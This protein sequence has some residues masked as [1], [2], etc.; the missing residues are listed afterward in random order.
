MIL[1]MVGRATGFSPEYVLKVAESASH[2]YKA[3]PIDKR[4]GGKR[5]IHQP[6]KELKAIQRCLISRFFERLPVHQAV[7]SY[8][9]RFNIAKHAKRHITN[10]YLLRLDFQDFFPSLKSDD[11]VLL[12]NNELPKLSKEDV[13]LICKIVCREQVLTIGAPSSP[14]LSNALLFDFDSFCAKKA[15]EMNLV[16]TRYSDDIYF[17][18]NFP[19]VLREVP[20]IIRKQLR[21]MKNPRLK[22]N[23]DKTVF[24][25]KKRKRMVT[26]LVITSKNKISIGRKKKREI[27]S[28][29]Y[30]RA[31]GELKSAKKSYLDGITSYILSV[32]PDF[33]ERLRKKHPPEKDVK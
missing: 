19:N 25:S 13:E 31:Q 32:E 33:I 20:P 12:L 16:Y 7:F 9:K 6:A 28:L 14:M 3:Y 21:V 22:L 17:S 11:L 8:R 2:R 26:G 30:R 29:Y 10:N 27:K 5:M 1:E 15:Q 4:T 18:T 24:T 23:K